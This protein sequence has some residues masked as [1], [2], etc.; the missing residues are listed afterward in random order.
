[1]PGMKQ[2]MTQLEAEQAS[3]IQR[4]QQDNE[5][6]RK[7][8]DTCIQ[9]LWYYAAADQVRMGWE[10]ADG[11]VKENEDGGMTAYLTLELLGVEG[12]GAVLDADYNNLPA[13]PT[14]TSNKSIEELKR[15]VEA[16]VC[17]RHRKV[18]PRS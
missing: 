2:C 18:R 17:G 3:I 11:S 1:M 6:L 13:T 15:Q 8:L 10:L 9:T 5:Q 12:A 16:I 14:L 4:M 7:H